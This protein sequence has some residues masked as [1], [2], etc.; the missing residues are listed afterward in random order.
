[1]NK[2]VVLAGG[3]GFI[4]K[5]LENEFLQKGYEVKIISRQP[6]HISWEDKK[7][8]IAALEG[9]EMLINLAGKS[10]DCRYN[11]HNKK[12]IMDSRTE[13]TEILGK[14]VLEALQPPELWI[15]SST[16]TIYRHAEDRPMTEVSG[17]IGTGFS[18]DVAKA[19]EESLFQFQLPKTRQIA[20]RIAIVLGKDG[21]VMIPFKNLVKFGLGGVQGPGSQMFSWIHIEDVHQ[22]I[23]FLKK[24]KDLSGVFNCAAPNPISNRE[25]MASLRQKMNRRIGLPSPEWLLEIGAVV[26]RTETELILKSRWVIPERL[27]QEG[28]T[29]Q[30][31]KINE[32]LDEI[33]KS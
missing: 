18:V 5:Y 22:I 13:T 11:D 24:R 25:F 27:E 21:G 12:V 30:Y 14:A 1:M 33:I 9:S 32:A 26:I 31:E 2:R 17:D 7:G 20:L 10:V 28:Y 8:I 15:N 19:W 4:G 23:L 16:A 29:F 6:Q 3:T